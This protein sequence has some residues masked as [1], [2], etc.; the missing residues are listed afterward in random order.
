MEEALAQLSLDDAAAVVLITDIS[1]DSLSLVLVWLP[2]AHDIASTASVCRMFRIAVEHAL[3]ARPFS[4]KVVTLGP[5][6]ASRAP[7][8]FKRL[9]VTPN[10]HIIAGSCHYPKVYV[11]RD[12]GSIVHIIAKAGV[13]FERHKCEP[14]FAALSDDHF[15][16]SSW[17]DTVKLWTVAGQ[18]PHEAERIYHH[19]GT[20]S[21]IATLH[22]GVHFVVGLAGRFLEMPPDVERAYIGDIRL[23]H[24]DGTH[25]HTFNRSMAGHTDHVKALAVTRDDR[26]IISGADDNLVKVWSVASMSLVSTCIGH[27]D[28]VCAVAAMPDGQRILSG[29]GDKTVRVWTLDG[30][31]ENTFRLHDLCVTALVPLPDNQHALS[32]SNDKTVKLFNANDGAVLRTITHEGKVSSIALLPDG[33]RFVSSFLIAELQRRGYV[34]EV[35]VVAEHGLRL[36]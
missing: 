22:D 18:Y 7:R 33:L 30:T 12:D 25:V 2:L 26:H 23:Y 28:G 5:T 31:P 1:I 11:W 17:D 4:G 35:A 32:G 29:S 16:C 6:P 8:P 10:G 20:V 13:D 19:V 14:L 21:S 3:V 15:V 27:G 24:T 9:A 36:A 34:D